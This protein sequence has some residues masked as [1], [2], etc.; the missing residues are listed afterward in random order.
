LALQRVRDM[1]SELKSSVDMQKHWQSLYETLFG[2]Y[3]KLWNE[4]NRM[5]ASPLTLSRTNSLAE[6]PW[7]G[8]MGGDIGQGEAGQGQGPR[9]GN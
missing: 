4:I 5:T 9:P 7:S 2:E 1:E 3:E 8:G 6:L